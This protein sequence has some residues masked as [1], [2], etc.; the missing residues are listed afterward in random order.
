MR[1]KTDRTHV[2][3]KNNPN[4]IDTKKGSDLMDT[5]GDFLSDFMDG[6][7]SSEK[8]GTYGKTKRQDT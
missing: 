8:G 2:V 7:G 4:D 6:I 1:N 5:L 3:P